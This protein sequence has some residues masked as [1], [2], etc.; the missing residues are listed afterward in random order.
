MDRCCANLRQELPVGD[1]R[2]ETIKYAGAEIRQNPD[3]GIELRQKP[4][5]INLM[6]SA[7]SLLGQLPNHCWSHPSCGHVVGNS[8]GLRTTADGT[9]HFLSPTCKVFNTGPPSVT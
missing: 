8:H 6:K 9:K 5:L 1:F 4:I 2:T 7:P 3:V